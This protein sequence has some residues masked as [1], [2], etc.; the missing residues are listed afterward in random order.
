MATATKVLTP[1]RPAAKAV[2]ARVA[3]SAPARMVR[4]AQAPALVQKPKP[5]IAVTPSGKTYAS[6]DARFNALFKQQKEEA[7]RAAVFLSGLG[8]TTSAPENRVLNAQE[9]AAVAAKIEAVTTQARAYF[10]DVQANKAALST[11]DSTLLDDVE[12]RLNAAFAAALEVGR[13]GFYNSAPLTI[14]S[15]GP[16]MTEIYKSLA[17]WLVKYAEVVQRYNKGSTAVWAGKA[18]SGLQSLASSLWDM[19]T[20]PI[21]WLKWGLIGVAVLFIAPPVLKIVL[22]ARKGGVDAAL[23]ESARAAEGGQQAIKSAA[24]GAAE[25]AQRGT[26]AY[27]TGGQS[28]VLRKAL[29][30]VSGVRSRRRRRMA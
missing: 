7:R 3:A 28:E 6:V 29:A 20:A 2:A 5:T 11:E 16:A 4:P 9:R 25:L 12:R 17:S 27:V 1:V 15:L 13:S 22:A 14:G 21:R 30:P 24:K 19:T 10:R 18:A 26:A 8:N 23:E